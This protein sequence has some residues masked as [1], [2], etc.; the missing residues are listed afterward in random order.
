ML[1]GKAK[2]SKSLTTGYNMFRGIVKSTG[3][4]CRLRFKCYGI[5]AENRFRLKAKRKS[6]FKSVD[7]ASV[8][9]TTDSRCV[10]ISGS[11][12]GYNMFRGIVKSTGYSFH[13]PV[14]PSLPCHAAPG[15]ITFQLECT[16][17]WYFVTCGPRHRPQ[18]RVCFLAIKT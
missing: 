6:P 9:S 5:C 12:A 13:S 10:C 15:A 18:Q 16:I 2:L 1:Q 3:Y 4:R 11:N 8:Q 17:Y 14:S 7:G